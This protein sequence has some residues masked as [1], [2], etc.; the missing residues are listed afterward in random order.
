MEI[1]KSAEASLRVEK[2]YSRWI[3]VA[4]DVFDHGAD[5]FDINNLLIIPK[6]GKQ[7]IKKTSCYGGSAV[8]PYMVIPSSR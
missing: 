7:L 2:M 1:S 4:H 8:N 3:W 6:R 5:Q